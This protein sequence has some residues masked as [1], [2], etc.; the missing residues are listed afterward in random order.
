MNATL[1][2]W[3]ENWLTLICCFSESSDNLQKLSNFGGK[4]RT[5]FIFKSAKFLELHFQK[6]HFI[7]AISGSYRYFFYIYLVL[8]FGKHIPHFLLLE[9]TKISLKIG[10]FQF[11]V[12]FERLAFTVLSNLGKIIL[13]FWD[14]IETR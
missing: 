12:E 3:F 9:N 5:C 10:S 8:N 4:C 2:L 14:R 13:Q 1:F 11:V 7:F 6:M